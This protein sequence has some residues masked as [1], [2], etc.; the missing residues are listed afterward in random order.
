M[1]RHTLGVLDDDQSIRE[2]N[3]SDE[4]YE[5]RQKNTLHNHLFSCRRWGLD[6]WDLKK[7][8]LEGEAPAEP[9]ERSD[10][11]ISQIAQIQQKHAIDL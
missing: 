2:R 10:P 8:P 5:Q 7:F 3:A 11:Q 1:A 6:R 9:F 4:R